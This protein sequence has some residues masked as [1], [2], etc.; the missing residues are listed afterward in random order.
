MSNTIYPTLP[1]LAFQVQR[2]VMAPPVHVRTTPSRREFRAR[3]ATVPLYS[4][5]LVYE[6]LRAH[7]TWV[8]LQTLVGFFNARGGAFDSF[9]FTDP[10]DSQATVQL[11]G[12]GNAA[13]TQFTLTR[14]FGGFAESV[15]AV[16]GTVQIYVNGTVQAQPAQVTVSGNLATFTTAPA[17]GAT[18]TWTGAFYRRV[19]F[20]RDQLDTV[21]FMRDLWDARKVELLS[22]KP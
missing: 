22:L 15:D 13:T 6:F 10:D 3:D 8:E 14:S 17:S 2:T 21:K 9:L 18:L 19:R 16:N 11:L 4:Y 5:T 1:G 20:A 7:S 12:T